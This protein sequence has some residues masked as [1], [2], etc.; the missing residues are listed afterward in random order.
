[1]DD[2]RL[3]KAKARRI[4]DVA[5]GYGMVLKKAG[6]NELKMVCPHPDHNDGDPSC[7]INTKNNL[8]KC[9]GCGWGGSV[10]DFVMGVEGLGIS[11]AINVLVGDE[12]H[13]PPKKKVAKVAAKSKIAKAGNKTGQWDYVDE[14]G[15]K[16]YASIR[17]DHPDGGKEFRM[18]TYSGDA[19]SMG[20]SGDVRR[21]PYRLD[22]FP[23]HSEVWFTEG[24][25]CS[26][27][28][29]KL[30]IFSSCVAGGSK[31]KLDGI[32]ECFKGMDV[33]LLP[34][35]DKTGREFMKSFALLLQD[36]A[37][38][39]R[40]IDV[41]T[42]RNKKGYDVFDW[43]KDR[44]ED[45][46][47]TIEVAERIT[48]MKDASLYMLD[49]LPAHILD[50]RQR[51]AECRLMYTLEGFD[52]GDFIPSLKGIVRPLIPGDCLGV[53]GD[54]GS[55]KTAMLS[56]ISEWAAPMTVLN[57]NIEL[58]TGVFYEREASGATGIPASK[59]EERYKSGNPVDTGSAL[60]HIYT[61][62]LFKVT[63]DEIRKQFWI[64]VRLKK[65]W[66]E[67]VMIDYVQ[68]MKGTGARYER[69]TD[70]AE[71]I[72]ILAK[73]FHTRMVFTSQKSRPPKVKGKPE[74][75]TPTLH[76]AKDS[77][78]LENSMSVYMDLRPHPTHPDVKKGVIL[79]NTRGPTGVEF[80][81]GWIGSCTKFVAGGLQQ[82][83]D[84]P[85]MFGDEEMPDHT[86]TV[87]KQDEADTIPF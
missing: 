75:I 33:V 66:P 46:M 5:T 31:A 60:S 76:D 6:G 23:D 27:A 49:G 84:I 52:L 20:L 18:A 42:P 3:G 47:T 36:V 30:G 79:K 51:E 87:D 57:F 45:G 86:G 48:T 2:G 80:D 19:L 38:S 55:G 67:F 69:T 15:D 61:V 53:V 14:M 59:I 37:G 26:D 54:T 58:S 17:Y 28:L 56:A 68:L 64:F 7:Y 34:D 65:L 70:N 13:S 44:K 8:F 4:Q 63:P 24:E 81:I 50:H 40:I 62:P 71:E 41:G 1:M 32:A 77:G 74:D 85:D 25:K 39:V 83:D 22:R 78:G 9:H 35:N 72:R 29:S 73:E 10:I 11:Q 82:P 12:E 16:L 21:V 43:I